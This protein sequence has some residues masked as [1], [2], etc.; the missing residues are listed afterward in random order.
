MS[1][2]RQ[3]KTYLQI[4]AKINDERKIIELGRQE[5]LFWVEEIRDY[6]ECNPDK[7]IGEETCDWEK[8]INAATEE[9]MLKYSMRT[10]KWSMHVGLPFL[11]ALSVGQD[12][13]KH[14][15]GSMERRLNTTDL[16]LYEDRE[17]YRHQL[18]QALDRVFALGSV[19]INLDLADLSRRR[20]DKKQKKEGAR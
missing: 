9:D 19:C 8:V 7:F 1:K 11:S 4:P 10:S 17:D 5:M 14:L 13:Y 18:L 2:R 6:K 20:W 16:F 12:I 15:P 3:R